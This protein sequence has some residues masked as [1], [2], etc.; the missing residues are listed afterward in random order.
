M[1][2][3]SMFFVVYAY[4]RAYIHLRIR[5]QYQSS[6]LADDLATAPPGPVNYDLVDCLYLQLYYITAKQKTTLT[7][8]SF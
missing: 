4:F 1:K 5:T 8:I 3:C 6:P 7:A 2:C